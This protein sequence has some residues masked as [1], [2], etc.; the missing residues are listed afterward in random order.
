MS[1]Q[2]RNDEQAARLWKESETLLESVGF[3]PA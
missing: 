2:A 1:A 3:A